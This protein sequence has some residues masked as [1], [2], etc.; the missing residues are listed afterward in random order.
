MRLPLLVLALLAA[1]PLPAQ[2]GA[3]PPHVVVTGH[4]EVAIAPD[5]AVL[6]VAVEARASTAAAA[7]AAS[8]QRTRA[9]HAAL[10]QGTP[11][12]QVR[13][14]GYTVQ[15]NVPTDNGRQRPDGYT[16]VNLLR[17]ETGRVDEVGTLIDAAL[18]AGADRIHSVQFSASDPAEARRSA[19]SQA[20]TQARRDA[21]AMAAAAGASLGPLVELST[22]RFDGA[23]GVSSAMIQIRGVSSSPTSITPGEL[24]VQARV[25]TR[26]R[27]VP[28]S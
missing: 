7:G 16:A 11:S 25:L 5:R 26:W 8:A 24:T 3:E 2:Q 17:V 21:E 19:L 14:A 9:V 13:T 20:I 6:L 28:G 27:L 4:A 18:A 15:P 23:P 22:E 1:V 10:A 12:A